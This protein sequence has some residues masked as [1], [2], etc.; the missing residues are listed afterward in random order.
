MAPKDVARSS[1]VPKMTKF[2]RKPIAFFIFYNFLD[3]RVIVQFM[4]SPPL[5]DKCWIMLHC[6]GCDW[7]G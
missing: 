6:T 4:V 1:K 7:N 5:D 3:K 2:L